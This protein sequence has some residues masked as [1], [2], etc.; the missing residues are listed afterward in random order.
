MCIQR[1][2]HAAAH[3][4]IRTTRALAHAVPRCTQVRR[5]VVQNDDGCWVD[6]SKASYP[7]WVHGLWSDDNQ[8]GRRQVLRHYVGRDGADKPARFFDLKNTDRRVQVR[9][10]IHNTSLPLSS[11][12]LQ[13]LIRLGM[14]CR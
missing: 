4:R 10:R 3:G 1:A 8:T 2:R 13:H 7:L 5:Y 9:M 11:P 6:F 14:G 12:A